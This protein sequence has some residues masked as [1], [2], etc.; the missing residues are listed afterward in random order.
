MPKGIWTVKNF[1]LFLIVVGLGVS[2]L[3]GAATEAAE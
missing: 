2:G 1:G 3:V